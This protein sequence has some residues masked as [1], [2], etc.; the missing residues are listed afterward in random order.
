MLIVQ[1]AL[2]NEPEF[3]PSAETIAME[4]DAA[5]KALAQRVQRRVSPA[6]SAAVNAAPPVLLSQPGSWMTAV[7]LC[8]AADGTLASI[9]ITHASGIEELDAAVVGAFQTTAP[10]EPVSAELLTDGKLCLPSFDF[11]V[12]YGSKAPPVDSKVPGLPVPPDVHRSSPG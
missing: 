3:A 6:W 5:R 7:S 12:Q 10:F 9:V 11:T 8:L 1:I 4:R 2:A